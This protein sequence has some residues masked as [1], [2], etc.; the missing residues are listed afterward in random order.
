MKIALL[1]YTICVCFILLNTAY[2]YRVVGKLKNRDR[3]ME[4]AGVGFVMGMDWRGLVH[5]NDQCFIHS[6]AKA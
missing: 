2:G 4:Y 3:L 5:I 1:H 6:F